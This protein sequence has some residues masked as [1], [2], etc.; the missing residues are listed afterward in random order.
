MSTL[1]LLDTSS[2]A[3]RAVHAVGPDKSAR[4]FVSMVQSLIGTYRPQGLLFAKDTKRE[5]LERSKVFP[6]Y[7]AGRS[8]DPNISFGVRE[9]E[10]RLE[11]CNA[12]ILSVP[13]AEADDVLAS[14]AHVLDK[15]YDLIILVSEDKDLCQ[16]VR[17]NV[18]LHKGNKLHDEAA[19]L[20]RWLVSARQVPEVQALCGDAA[21]NI[22]GLDG[23]GPKTAAK[24][25]NRFG[26]L[27]AVVA[28]RSILSSSLSAQLESFPWKRNLKLTT[29][30]TDLPLPIRLSKIE[31]SL[32]WNRF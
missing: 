21:D 10:S 23:V 11:S 32:N 18:R 22:P 15:I 17:P 20:E 19:V 2:L 6:E 31:Q 8:H 12:P 30:R 3:Y 4:V 5:D 24:L 28:N 27:E 14:V 26:S 7:K 9:I 13:G 29:L 25:I 1:L 16:V